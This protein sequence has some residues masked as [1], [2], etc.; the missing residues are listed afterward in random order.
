[1]KQST[2]LVISVLTS[3]LGLLLLYTLQKPGEWISLR[4]YEPVSPF[5]DATRQIHWRELI[6]MDL[7]SE[8]EIQRRKD[9][10]KALLANLEEG[11][12]TYTQNEIEGH[13]FEQQAD[14]YFEM[15]LS[16]NVKTI[17]ETGFNAGHTAINW[18]TAAPNATL[19]AFDIVGQHYY[20]KIGKAIIDSVFP[21]RLVLVIG[22]S[23]VTIPR[24]IAEHPDIRCDIAEVDGYHQLDGPHKD[25]GNFHEMAHANTILTIDDCAAQHNKK[26]I[27]KAVLDAEA[28]GFLINQ[29]DFEYPGPNGPRGPCIAQINVGVSVPEDWWSLRWT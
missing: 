17:C 14:L 16:R 25:I 5:G 1:M 4:D 11:L 6:K 19:Y 28:R 27:G 7:P 21:G 13:L 20:Y 22:D 2:T 12:S 10:S 23:R 3:G 24:F 18:L 29:Q 8:Q 26:N 9:Q 15:A